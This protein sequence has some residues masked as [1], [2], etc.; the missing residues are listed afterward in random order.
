MATYN[1]FED[2]PVWKSAKELAVA[3]YKIT[4]QSKISKDY[5]LSNQIQRAA[6]SVSINIA[7]GFERGGKQEFIQFLYVA[8]GSC[9]E[10]RSQLGICKDVNY[11]S[12]SEYNQ[13]NA[14]AIEVSKQLNGFIQYLKGSNIAGQKFHGVNKN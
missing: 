9:G 2:L 8:R 10:L 4:A 6:V 5:G 11:L 7:E 12:E 1:S 13:I 14:L 3:V